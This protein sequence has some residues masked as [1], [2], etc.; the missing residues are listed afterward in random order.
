MIQ[1]LLIV[2]VLGIIG[3]LTFEEVRHFYN[4]KKRKKELQRNVSNTLI[5]NGRFVNPFEEF[6]DKNVASIP[7]LFYWWLTRQR[8][9]IPSEE[10]IRANLPLYKPNLKPSLSESWIQ[11]MT[12]TWIGKHDRI[13]YRSIYLFC[14]N[15]R[16]QYPHR[17]YIF[18]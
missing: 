3:V 8:S 10:E 16:L 2:G 6:G 7:N 9:R 15:G 17:P 18:V 12:V 5:V 14:S 13:N 1:K 11:Q 4:S